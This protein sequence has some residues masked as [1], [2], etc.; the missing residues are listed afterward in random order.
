[1]HQYRGIGIDSLQIG[2]TAC[3]E[4]FMHNA[5]AIPHEHIRA[6]LSFYVVTQILVGRPENFFAL[7]CQMFDHI[8]GYA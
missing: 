6:G 8:K 3:L 7:F 4:F 1:M 5:R 2:D